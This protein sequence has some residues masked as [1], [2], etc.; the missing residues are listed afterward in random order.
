[1]IYKNPV[2]YP[3]QPDFLY[4]FHPLQLHTRCL[5]CQKRARPVYQDAPGESYST[6]S[7][8]NTPSD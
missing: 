4:A 1:M 2:A 8:G 6:P 5:I 7:L 3:Q